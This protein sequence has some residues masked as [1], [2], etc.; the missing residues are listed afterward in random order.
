M[1]CKKCRKDVR[2]IGHFARE[3]PEYRKKGRKKGK[4]SKHRKV[5]TIYLNGSDIVIRRGRD[6]SRGP[7]GSFRKWGSTKKPKRGKKKGGLLK[8]II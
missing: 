8:K 1:Y 5:R 4:A 2:S 6:T 3:H 7:K